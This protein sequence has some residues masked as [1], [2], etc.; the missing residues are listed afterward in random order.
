MIRILNANPQ[1]DTTTLGCI[2]DGVLSTF[3]IDLNKNPFDM[4]L[5]NNPPV[6]IFCQSFDNDGNAITGVTAT[7]AIDA[8][9]HA[10]ITVTFPAPFTGLVSVNL[11]FQYPTT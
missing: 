2:G 8:N 10:Q 4:P 9:S 1:P 11:T 3:T 6:Q 7:I 5:F